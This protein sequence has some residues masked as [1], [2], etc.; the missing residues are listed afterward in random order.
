MRRLHCTSSSP[1]KQYQLLTILQENSKTIIQDGTPEERES[2]INTLYTAL[3]GALLLIHPFMPFLTEELWQRLP[4]RP[5]DTTPSIVVAAYP[6]HDSTLDDPASEAAYELVLGCSKGIRSLLAEYTIKEDGTA[7][8]QAL[9]ETSHST[10]SSQSAAIKSLSG[11]AL[12]ALTILGPKDS[13]PAGCA[14][15]PVSANAAVYVHVKGRV[16]IDKEI[17]KASAKRDKASQVV[18]KQEKVL[19]GIR[20]AAS[21][22]VVEAEEA[23]LRDAMA[24]VNALQEAIDQ[25]RVL[26]LE[27]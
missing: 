9:D 1:Q 15:F 24:E 4:R 3:E 16:D 23:K 5:N 10:A 22:A 12:G 8:V 19:E 20:E 6:Q 17:E 11:K 25:F 26:K 18:T 13:K 2:A 27:G 7:F 14:V 21:A